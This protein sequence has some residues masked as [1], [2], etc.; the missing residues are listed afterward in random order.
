MQIELGLITIIV[1]VVSLLSSAVAIYVGLTARNTVLKVQ[2][3]LSKFEVGFLRELDQR[4]VR[5]QEHNLE[6]DQA[7]R[8]EGGYRQGQKEKFEGLGID[9]FRDRDTVSIELRD[10]VAMLR[11]EESERVRKASA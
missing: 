8:E 11:K 3:D 1:G 2:L 6:R 9:V 4:Y 10:I 5:V 7:L